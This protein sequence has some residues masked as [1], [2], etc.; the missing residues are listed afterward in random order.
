MAVVKN[1]RDFWQGVAV[2]KWLQD[3]I[4]GRDLKATLRLYLG[5]LL[6]LAPAAAFRG[7]LFGTQ[8]AFQATPLLMLILVGAEYGLS[9]QLSPSGKCIALK[10]TTGTILIDYPAEPRIESPSR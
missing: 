4:E 5:G 1:N 2:C 9:K 7:Y 10:Y 6:V 8:T 3:G